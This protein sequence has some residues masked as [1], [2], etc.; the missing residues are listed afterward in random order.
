MSEPDPGTVLVG[1]AE[2]RG[3][4]ERLL[5]AL[6]TP[7]MRA[8]VVADN[9]VEADLRGVDS[10]GAN[11]MALYHQRVSSGHLLPDAPITTVEDRGST[12]RLDAG[13]GFGQVA[14]VQAV[15]LATARAAEHGVATVTVRE[16]THLGALGYY[17]ARAAEAGY[18]AMVFQNG[19]S[20]VPPFGGTTGVFSTNPFSYAV[21]AGANPPIVYDVATT[22]AAG[23]K[24]LL[25]RKRG[26]ASIPPG[27]ANDEEGRP[28]TDPQ[29]ASVFQLQWAAGHKG[30][31]LAMLVEIMGG[32]LADSC[33]G[34]VENSASEL[35]GRD[36]IAKG[37]AFVA[38]DVA[39]FLPRGEFE[40]RVDG[41]IVDVHASAL[42]PGTERIYV[43]GEIEAE[44]RAER[45]RLGIPLSRGLVDELDRVAGEL[46]CPPLL[47]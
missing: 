38:L 36:R 10:H 37:A 39:R 34:T 19:P 21:P 47:P 4:L 42:A 29:A 17:T 44:R 45:R 16:L 43:P 12:V 9:L 46:G 23:N 33:Y 41:L 11:L 3:Q 40:R 35:A 7:A 20:I 15:D 28:T 30:F 27:W 1:E 24:I 14:G 5:G 8:V 32:V 6:G 2:L 18:L 26:D 13:L 31:G 22:A 25:A